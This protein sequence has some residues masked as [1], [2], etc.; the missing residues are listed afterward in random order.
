VS[1]PDDATSPTP[2]CSPPSGST[3]PIGTTT[4]H[5]SVS[6]PDD[7]NSPQ[8]TTFTVTVN[9]SD[10]AL[11]NLPANQTVN[12]TSPQGAVVTYTPPTVVDEDFPLPTVACAPPSGSTFAIGVTTVTCTVSAA[13]DTN[14][15][16][17]KAF[18]VDVL[19]AAAQLA[20]LKPSV[21]GVGPG[22]SLA[23]KIS[24]AQAD[25][26]ANDTADAC[27]VLNAFINEVKAQTGKSISPSTAASLIAS[28]TN[29]RAV[30]GC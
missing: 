7:T 2:S 28:A 25:V 12:A 13:G 26:A 8:A 5:C 19:G 6:D 24:K 20:N 29:I 27:A 1:D 3:F 14:S 11:T 30:L 15:P 22:T 18:T 10:L 9:D 17:S 16:V 4:V 23:D 21:T